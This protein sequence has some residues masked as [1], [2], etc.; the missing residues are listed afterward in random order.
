MPLL[1]PAAFL[2]VLAATVPAFAQTTWH[3]DASAAPPGDG[4]QAHPYASIAYAVQRPTTVN[5]DRILVAPGTYTE[6][7]DYQFKVL[8][9]ESSA[10]PLATRILGHVQLGDDVPY[11]PA[12]LV[13]FRV[14][15]VALYGASL[16]HCILFDTHT[17][18][19]SALFVS[20]S[21]RIDHCTVV[22][23]QVAIIEF[24]FNTNPL[25]I[26]NS[27]FLDNAVFFNSSTGNAHTVQYSAG[28]AGGP[29]PPNWSIVGNVPGDP[30][31]WDVASGDL[32]LK[33]G[34]VCIDAGDPASP[35]DPDGS[36]ADVGAIAYDATYAPG[37]TVYCEGKLHSQGCV[38][39][40][41]YSGSASASSASPF[42]VTATN[43]V[44]H[45]RGFLF[46][47]FAPDAQPFQGGTYCVLQP[48]RRTRGQDS[49][50]GPAP[51]TGSY[52]YDFNPR[53]QSG[54]DPFLVPG[55]L[56]Y[57][58]YWFRDPADPQ[59]FASGLSNG[60]CFGIAP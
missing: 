9:V 40:I 45:R 3:V 23:Y 54:A 15:S 6:N 16:E 51:C 14:D 46:Y 22:G 30:G 10:G 24:L 4:T 38:P 7:V 59:G 20:D 19:S 18:G 1:S 48:T 39:S 44:P 56:V 43:V 35:L 60:L 2:A 33:P 36:R 52:S 34:S 55:A 50:G 25:T 31:L 57:A 26:R 11:S 53:I 8:T 49:L 5:G 32:H 29:Y 41:A 21:A 27:V 42:L 28:Q 58:Q 37:P 17:P 47:G 12:R 13:G